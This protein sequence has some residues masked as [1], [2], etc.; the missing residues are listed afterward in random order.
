MLRVPE[1]LGEALK[2]LGGVLELGRSVH[3]DRL[4]GAL[5]SAVTAVPPDARARVFAGVNEFL[6]RSAC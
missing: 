1:R 3:S 4:T 6:H 2:G 5:S